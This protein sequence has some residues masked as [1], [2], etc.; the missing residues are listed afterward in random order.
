MSLAQKIAI[1]FESHLHQSLCH[2]GVIVE[3]KMNNYVQ[4][5]QKGIL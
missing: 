3:E 2:Q 4:V 1:T 5:F